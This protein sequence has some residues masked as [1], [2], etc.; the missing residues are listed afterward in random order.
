MQLTA[1]TLGRLWERLSRCEVQEGVGRL[2]S[3]LLPWAT[4][5]V[6]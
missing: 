5:T 3:R 6:T 1:A 4:I 2:S